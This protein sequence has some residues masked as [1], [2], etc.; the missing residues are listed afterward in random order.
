MLLEYTRLILCSGIYPGEYNSC[1]KSTRLHAPL[2]LDLKVVA[3]LW[4][5]QTSPCLHADILVVNGN[6]LS[7]QKAWSTTRIA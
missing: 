3:G 5:R 1:K 6:T 7:T 2:N 4:F